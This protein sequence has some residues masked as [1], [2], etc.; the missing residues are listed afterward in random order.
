ML[1]R[2]RLC[3]LIIVSTLTNA[4]GNKRASTALL[5]W[6]LSVII[7]SIAAMMVLADVWL[8]LDFSRPNLLL[9]LKV[10]IVPWWQVVPCVLMLL[11]RLLVLLVVFR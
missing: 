3:R 4:R 7:Q 5:F 8:E 6:L 11:L 9:L 10:L 1:S 2:G